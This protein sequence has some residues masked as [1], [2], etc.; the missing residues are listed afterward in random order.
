MGETHTRPVAHHV[1]H[2][3]VN[4]TSL[5][6][7]MVSANVCRLR[8]TCASCEK[9]LFAR[10]AFI[11]R[12]AGYRNL[13]QEVTAY[14]TEFHLDVRASYNIAWDGIS[15]EQQS[16]GSGPLRQRM[17]AI[18]RPGKAETLCLISSSPSHQLVFLL[19]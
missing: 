15:S 5:G 12:D 4:I 13:E 14:P 1:E 8:T 18:I 10:R 2:T 19:H 3:R 11:L 16:E 9:Q 17:T 7:S 6:I